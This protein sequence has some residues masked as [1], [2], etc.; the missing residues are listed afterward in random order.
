MYPVC[1]L[2][3]VSI[4][5]VFVLIRNSKTFTAVG[6]YFRSAREFAD[7]Y[8]YTHTHAYKYLVIHI[9]VCAGVCVMCIHISECKNIC[10]DVR[11]YVCSAFTFLFCCLI[12]CS[13]H[14]MLMLLL[15]SCDCCCY[16]CCCCSR[17]SQ[18]CVAVLFTFDFVVLFD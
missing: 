4:R 15:F 18:F 2:Y 1:D 9:Y 8:L 17:L 14:P 13:M 12:M 10:S 16:C 6:N 7:K 3:K 5:F 11:L